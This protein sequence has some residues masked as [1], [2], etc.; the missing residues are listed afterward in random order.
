MA[1]N[2]SMKKP[3]KKPDRYVGERVLNIGL[4]PGSTLTRF[5]EWARGEDNQLEASLAVLMKAEYVPIRRFNSG[6]PDD[7]LADCLEY[8]ITYPELKG[9]TKDGQVEKFARGRSAMQYQTSSTHRIDANDYKINQVALY[10]TLLSALATR[11]MLSDMETQTYSD[12]YLINLMLALPPKELDDFSSRRN[13]EEN[14]QKSFVVDMPHINRTFTIKVINI[15]LV[16]EPVAAA[17]AYLSSDFSGERH[18]VNTIF[19]DVGGRNRSV[20]ACM[21]GVLQERITYSVLNDSGATFLSNIGDDLAMDYGIP[22]PSDTDICSALTRCEFKVHSQVIPKFK[23]IVL[24]C[25]KQLGK[26][27]VSCYNEALA[28]FQIASSRIERIVLSGRSIPA[29]INKKTGEEFCPSMVEILKDEFP[30]IEVVENE[31]Q[32]PVLDG[33]SILLLHWIDIL[34]QKATTNNEEGEGY[35]DDDDDIY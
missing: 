14:L 28:N 17:T 10:N 29:I 35:E 24:D 18:K 7:P 21:D 13:F 9:I 26:S 11:C 34:E 32:S 30:N 20:V 12:S 1:N 8:S 22:R 2:S 16:P 4:D 33:T 27:I 19:I 23:D 3:Y 15:N 6:S 31:A 25:K 5:M